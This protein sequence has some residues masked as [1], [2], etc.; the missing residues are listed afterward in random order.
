[1]P[2]LLCP[3]PDFLKTSQEPNAVLINLQSVGAN[4]FVFRTP[5]HFAFQPLKRTLS[6]QA[7][8]FSHQQKLPSQPQLLPGF[9]VTLWGLAERLDLGREGELPCLVLQFLDGISS[10]SERKKYSLEG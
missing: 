8:S 2:E 10:F 9:R 5:G 4:I 6:Q 7:P 3:Q 1:M